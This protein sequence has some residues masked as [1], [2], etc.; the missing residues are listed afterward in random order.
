MRTVRFLD[1]LEGAA[2]KQGVKPGS[3]SYSEE[4]I[5]ELVEGLNRWVKLAWEYTAWPETMLVEYREYMAEWSGATTYGEG[6]QVFYEDAYWESLQAANTGNTPAEGA[7]WTAAT[8][9]DRVIGLDQTGETPIGTVFSVSQRNPDTSSSPFFL[10]FTMTGAG[11]QLDSLAPTSVYVKFRKRAPV[12]TDVE[13]DEAETGYVAGSLVQGSDGECY[14]GL[15]AVPVGTDPADGAAPLYWEK[16]DFPAI[17]AEVVKLGARA[18][19]L[20]EDGQDDK[21]DAQEE[22]A[23]GEL[24]RVMDVEVGQQDQVPRAR[25]AGYG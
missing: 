11:I 1:V 20:R 13:W 12:F 21:A 16:V 25:M 7:W 2:K 23:F 3:E 18:D 17:F 22:K 10:S 15:Q 9:Y 19:G 8:E 4:F 24:V 5:G 14:K 6:S